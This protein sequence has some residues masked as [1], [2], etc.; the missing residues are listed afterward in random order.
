MLSHGHWDHAGGLPRTFEMI[1]AAGRTGEMPC[2]LH[3]GMFAQRGRSMPNGKV[4]PI[5]RVASPDELAH[6]GANPVVTDEPRTT[7]D[8]RFYVSGEI[9][10]VTAY[11]KGLPGAVRRNAADTV[12]EPDPW[13]M[14]ERFLA[15]QVEDKGL[16]VFSACSHA[17]IVNVLTHARQTFPDVP[18]HAVMGGLHLAGATVEPIIPDTVRDLA[19]FD[20][21]WIVPCH[22]T[23]WR[24]VTALVNAFGEE[25]VAP[26]A[27]GKRF[28]F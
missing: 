2:Y 4:M 10:R 28:T 5:K 9:P 21:R 11:E 16:I 13:I 26:G 1:R 12:W 8:D 20:L 3:P 6:A 14:D 19:A 22:C 25:H 27:V 7:L 18:L 24:A 17:G 15:V 23:G